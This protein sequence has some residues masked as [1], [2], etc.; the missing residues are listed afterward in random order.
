MLR[1]L[2]LAA[3]L[4]LLPGNAFILAG[5]Q[6]PEAPRRAIGENSDAMAVIHT[7]GVGVT[8]S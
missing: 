5:E 1:R 4:V 3:V 8:V 7:S 6:S 2:W